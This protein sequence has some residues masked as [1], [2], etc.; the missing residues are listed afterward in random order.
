[1]QKREILGGIVAS[2]MLA[3]SGPAAA[4]VVDLNFEADTIGEM[5]VAG[6]G[7]S[8]HL[9]RDYRTLSLFERDAMVDWP[10]AEFYADKAL[11][12]KQGRKVMPERV[13]DWG[14]ENDAAIAELKA[15]RTD[16]V[17]LLSTAR[18]AHP[19]AAAQAQAYY[20]CWIEQQEEGWQRS[21][22]AG[23]KEKFVL[24]MSQLEGLMAEPAT[25]PF[26]IRGMEEIGVVFFEFDKAVLTPKAKKTLDTMA[27]LLPNPG[28]TELVIAGHADRSGPKG[29]NEALSARRAAAV[30]DYLAAKGF[31]KTRVEEYDMAAYGETRPAIPT[32]DGVRM[33][34]NR[35]VKIQA[36]ADAS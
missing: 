8:D 35:R 15:A 4:E 20:D 11:M 14:V 34:E 16:L 19:N 22:I 17:A 6:Q 27:A 10:D 21:H 18:S 29:Y 26:S 13:E 2:A 7:F 33:P 25:E 9:A 30:Q 32:A 24:A 28:T 31:T 36:E 5:K 3:I 1:M 23:C 12:A